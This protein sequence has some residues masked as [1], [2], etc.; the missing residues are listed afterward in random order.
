MRNY[1]YNPEEEAQM[2]AYGNEWKKTNRGI[3]GP[4]AWRQFKQKHPWAK[5]ITADALRQKYVRMKREQFWKYYAIAHAS[6]PNGHL[7]CNAAVPVTDY[8]VVVKLID[9]Y[10]CRST[11]T[12]NPLTITPVANGAET[13]VSSSSVLQITEVDD[14]PVASTS[15]ISTAAVTPAVKSLASDSTANNNAEDVVTDDIPVELPSR[16]VAP[17]QE[18]VLEDAIDTFASTANSDEEDCITDDIPVELPSPCVATTQELVL[19]DAIDSDPEKEENAEDKT[20]AVVV[21]SSEAE[22]LL[23]WVIQI[24][25]GQMV[26]T[27]IDGHLMLVS[28]NKN[29][30]T[31]SVAVREVLDQAKR[32]LLHYLDQKCKEFAQ[33]LSI[34]SDSNNKELLVEMIKQLNLYLTEEI[35]K[36]IARLMANNN[37]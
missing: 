19:Q 14:S 18:F 17:T 16:T 12:L 24:L 10:V 5:K 29:S 30:S 35:N 13:A 27:L 4:S 1:Q 31:S 26:P 7:T 32:V 3:R 34:L 6:C 9:D 21:A 11:E 36:L 25:E 22:E 33:K 28:R 37:Q 20:K 2:D 23:G 15:A 8:S